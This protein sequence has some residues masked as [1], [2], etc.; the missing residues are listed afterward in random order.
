MLKLRDTRAFQILSG[1]KVQSVSRKFFHQSRA[2]PP[3]GCNPQVCNTLP[4]RI[5]MK[6]GVDSHRQSKHKPVGSCRCQGPKP[7]LN[8]S[9]P[10]WLVTISTRTSR[11]YE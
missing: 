11:S 6:V 1:E 2:E 9:Q 8:N 10:C 3:R 5:G 4:Q 7:P